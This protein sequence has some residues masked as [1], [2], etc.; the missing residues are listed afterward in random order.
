L[1][2]ETP[3]YDVAHLLEKVKPFELFPR[4]QQWQRVLRVLSLD[5]A[6]SQ[7]WR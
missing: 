1:A 4:R 6:S 5:E 3:S 7:G 2:P